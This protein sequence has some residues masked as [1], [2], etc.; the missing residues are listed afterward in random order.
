MDALKM[1]RRGVICKLG[2]TLPITDMRSMKNQPAFIDLYGQKY[3]NICT[4]FLPCSLVVWDMAI[5]QIRDEHMKN[6]CSFV[7]SIIKPSP[8]T[9]IALPPATKVDTP[10]P[11]MGPTQ[12][13]TQSSLLIK[14]KKTVSYSENNNTYRNNNFRALS[15]ICNPK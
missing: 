14:H 3:S 7:V 9:L 13:S 12:M 2:P 1:M 6:P 11:H 15:C 5:S 10:T 4:F 8:S